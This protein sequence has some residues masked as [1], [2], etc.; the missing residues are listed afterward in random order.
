MLHSVSGS[1]YQFRTLEPINKPKANKEDIIKGLKNIINT[2]QARGITVT[3]INADNEFACA[4]DE[5]LPTRLNIAASEE[6]VGDVER[7]IRYIKEGTRKHINRLPYTHYPKVMVTGCAMHVL[8]S[9]NGLPSENGLSTVLSPHTLI[10]GEAA[11]SFKEICNL[12]FG[13]YVQT[14]HGRTTNDSTARTVGAISLFPSGNTSGGWYF[15]SLLT[16]NVIHRYS[17]TEM[18]A[19]ADIVHRVKELA[20]EQGQSLIGRNFK[21]TYNKNAIDDEIGDLL[22]TEDDDIDLLEGRDIQNEELALTNVDLGA[23]LNTVEDE[24]VNEELANEVA[25][26]EA[27]PNEGTI[28]TAGDKEE[29]VEGATYENDIE[30]TI[31]IHSPEEN[32]ENTNIHANEEQQYDEN[33][34]AA[35]NIL[36]SENNNANSEENIETETEQQTNN[37]CDNEKEQT[38]TRLRRRVRVNYKELHTK[39]ARQ[40]A[41]LK[42]K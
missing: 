22:L 41:R 21:Y 34:E 35:N 3:Q 25:I 20:I 14:S 33:T 28:A 32:E 5:V 23:P 37:T 38:N 36:E 2:Y 24:V 16:G 39:G 12:N 30:I 7:S 40:H 8:K 4:A 9:I 13:D 18:N 19:G 26:I 31:E 11:P 6:H 17:W 29:I 15:M 1:T 42:A 27:P 10:T